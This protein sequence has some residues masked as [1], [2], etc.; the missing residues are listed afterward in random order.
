ME[1]LTFLMVFARLFFVPTPRKATGAAGL[2]CLFTGKDGVGHRMFMHAVRHT[3]ADTVEGL[4]ARI[5][6]TKTIDPQ[7]WVEIDYTA[8]LT[9]SSIVVLETGQIIRVGDRSRVATTVIDENMLDGE[10]R[11]N[12][13]ALPTEDD[14]RR[15][16]NGLGYTL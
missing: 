4:E 10:V 7:Y 6:K 16:N 8:Y 11:A 14:V 12:P 1:G 3:S 5:A 15:L 2:F 13:Y 9:R